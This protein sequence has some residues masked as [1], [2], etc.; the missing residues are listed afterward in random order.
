[1]AV[2]TEG[3]AAVVIYEQTRPEDSFGQMMIQNLEVGVGPGGKF[4]GR[5]FR[6]RSKG[7]RSVIC[8]RRQNTQEGKVMRRRFISRRSA[9]F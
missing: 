8:H 1:M 9:I 6:E 5:V 3:P 2:A 4:F 7:R